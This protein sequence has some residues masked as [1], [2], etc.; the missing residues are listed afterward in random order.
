[1]LIAESLDSLKQLLFQTTKPSEKAV[2]YNDITWTS[3]QLEQDSTLYFA[4]QA[5]SFAQKNQL[6]KPLIT[7][8]LQLAEIFRTQ[9]LLEEATDHLAKAEQLLQN[10]NFEKEKARWLLFR[11]NLSYSQYKNEEAI[12]L[13]KEGYA[14]SHPKYPELCFDFCFRLALFY[15]TEGEYANAKVYLE[16]GLHYTNNPLQTIQLYN[17]WGTLSVEQQEYTKA[18][19]FYEKNVFLADSIH[20]KIEKS[21]A[22][23]NIGNIYLMQGSWLEAIEFYLKS[24]QLKEQVKDQEGLSELHHN[25][26]VVYKNQYRYDKSLEYFTKCETYYAANQDSIGL[27]ETWVNIALVY[28]LQ[29][30]LE[31][32]VQLLNKTL[33]I[34]DANNAV[35][36]ILL[37][38]QTNLGFAYMELGDYQK[39]ATYLDLARQAATEGQ[40]DFSLVNIYNLYGANFFYLKQYQQSIEYYQKALSLSKRLDLL[41]EQEAALFGLYE[42]TEKLGKAQQ[43]LDWYEQYVLVKDSLFSLETSHKLAE[44]QEQYDSQQKEQAIEQLQVEKEKIALENKLKQK[45]VSFLF[46]LVGLSLVIMLLLALL[47]WYRNKQQ[48]ERLQQTKLLHDKKVNQLMQQQEI[49]MLDAVV[50]AQ[51]KERKSIAK[52]IHDTLGSYLATLKY[53]HEAGKKEQLQEEEVRQYQTM[54]QLIAQTATEVRNIAHQMATGKKFDFNLKEAI[55]QLVQRVVN[56]EQFEVTFCYLGAS[57]ALPRHLELTLYRIVQELLSNILKHAQAS[58]V[59]LQINQLETELTVM[60]EDNGVGFELEKKKSGLGLKSIQERIEQLG[61]QWTVDTYPQRG[62]TVVIVFPLV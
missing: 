18:L 49:V 56:T 34:L 39:A 59:S 10:G 47:W 33:S 24:A 12:E 60:V 44:L 53:Q 50:N 19:A 11:G 32:A 28:I 36:H 51:Q 6:I 38:A 26:A 43:A 57:A 40:D 45:Q 35:D 58:N 22:Y 14:L 30:K 13:L 54:E 48:K 29:K 31:E 7:A 61:G 27:A 41:G 3:Y 25:L 52:E 23:Q 5:F 46:L 62:T 17:S 55:D 20:S 4:K 9:Y 42:S 16:K 21:R 15:E 37:T 1:M 8:H 2:L